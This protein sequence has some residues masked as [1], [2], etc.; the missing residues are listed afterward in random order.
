MTVREW[1]IVSPPGH[2]VRIEHGFWSG[3]ALIYLNGEKI[4][5]RNRKLW[6]LGLEH[7]FAIDGSPCILIV[8][9]RPLHFTYEL[10]VDGKLQ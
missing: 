2:T 8:I 1:R 4:F 9:S 10:W 3:R 6:D 7:R 5:E